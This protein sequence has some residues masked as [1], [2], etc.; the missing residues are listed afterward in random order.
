MPANLPPQ[1]FE[2]ERRLKTAKTPQEKIAI[3]EELLTIVPKHKGTEKLQALFKTKIAKLRQES[4]RRPAAS[5]HGPVV[6]V[7][8]SGAGQVVVIGPPNGGK[9]SIVRALTGRDV[10]VAAYPYTTRSA[11]PFMMPFVNIQVQ[12]VD[13]PPIAPDFL[14][15]WLPEIIKT[16]DAVLLAVDLSDP[17]A[18]PTVEGILGALKDRKVELVPPGRP[19]P[20]ER[21]PFLKHALCVGTR[22]DAEG[23][24]EARDELRVLFTDR[25]ETAAVSTVS[26]EGVEALR[27]AVF[28]LLGIVRVYSKAPGKK[29]D[30]A[31]PF[32]L[33]AGSTVLDMA[34]AVHKD[35]ALNLSFARIWSKGGGVEGLR[36]QRDHVLADEDVVELHL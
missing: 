1:Y 24:A 15:P 26:G 3:Y 19:V 2:V 30:L 7:E 4:E 22:L 27:R 16:A 8:K 35:F 13:T 33:R 5:K 18:A 23:A 21:G 20:A 31:S 36:V 17:E 32:T 6:R 28:D 11:S 9:S 14:E 25:F 34:R 12:L 10:E 29:A